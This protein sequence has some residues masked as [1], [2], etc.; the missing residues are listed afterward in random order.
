[1]VSCLALVTGAREAIVLSGLYMKITLSGRQENGLLDAVKLYCTK[2][3][4]LEAILA[5][6]AGIDCFCT[7]MLIGHFV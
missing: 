7:I 6:G 3:L 1:M 4:V 2:F 5:V